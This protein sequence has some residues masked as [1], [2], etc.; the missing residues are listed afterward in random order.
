MGAFIKKERQDEADLSFYAGFDDF[1]GTHA[2][3]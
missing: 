3:I 1:V 2:G